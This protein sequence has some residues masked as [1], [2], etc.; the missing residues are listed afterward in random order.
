MINWML[1]VEDV[2]CLVDD[3]RITDCLIQWDQDRLR[4]G[5]QVQVRISRG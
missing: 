2:A 5:R 4:E 3:M 1:E